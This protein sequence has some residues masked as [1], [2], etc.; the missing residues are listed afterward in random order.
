MSPFLTCPIILH[1]ILPT[2][3]IALTV[4]V[5]FEFNKWAGLVETTPASLTSPYTV[6]IVVSA[7]PPKINTV[8]AS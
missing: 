7:S 2:S 5:K 8:P 3:A 6:V 4:P 1:G